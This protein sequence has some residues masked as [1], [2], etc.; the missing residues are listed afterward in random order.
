MQAK[1]ECEEDVIRAIEE[2]VKRLGPIH[3]LVVWLFLCQAAVSLLIEC[4]LNHAIFESKDVPIWELSLAQW[5]R[6]IDVNLTGCFLFAREVR[7][8]QEIYKLFIGLITHIL[9]HIVL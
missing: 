8:V 1:A 7:H 9:Y 3:I 4:Q 6:T 2:S 5:Q